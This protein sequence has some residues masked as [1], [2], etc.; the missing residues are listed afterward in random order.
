V[1]RI[2]ASPNAVNVIADRVTFTIDFRSPED[3]VVDRAP[4]LIHQC[5]QRVCQRRQVSF[6]LT[7][8]EH[9]PAVALDPKLC[10]TLALAARTGGI[11]PIARTSSGALH[12]AAIL[13]PFLPVTMLFVASKDG[14]SHNPEEFSRIE[15]IAQAARILGELVATTARAGADHSPALPR[16]G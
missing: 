5:I 9:L 13:A 3:H 8:I 1:G 12:D 11:D 10:D 14:I 2:L 15:D 7:Q 16:Q 6:D 4:N